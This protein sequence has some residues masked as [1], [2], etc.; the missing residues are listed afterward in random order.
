MH[1]LLRKATWTAAG[2]VVLLMPVV[3]AADVTIAKGAIVDLALD[4]AL[5][6]RT[7]SVNDTFRAKLVQP[8]Y[9]E[10]EM[11][12]PANTVVHGR[13]DSVKS[14]RDGARSG[15]IGIKFVRI[16]LPN[17]ERKD[18]DAKLISLRQDRNSTVSTA[19][20]VST[21]RKVDVVLIG[22]ATPA[23]GRAHT[24]VGEN[25]AEEYSRTSLSE[26]E[27]EV[28]AGTVVSMEF[29]TAAKVPSLGKR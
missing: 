21:G 1:P 22:Q 27:V 2:L 3:A 13:V 10:G 16:E 29:D 23:D 14:L 5:D 19:S 18:I 6:S 26:G 7:A 24:L 12:L 20:K 4:E 17:G 11:V 15:Y 8:L 9:V 28:A 25:A